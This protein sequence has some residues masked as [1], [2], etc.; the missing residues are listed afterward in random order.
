MPQVRVATGSWTPFLIIRRMAYRLGLA[1]HSRVCLLPRK[2]PNP[3]LDQIEQAYIRPQVMAYYVIILGVDG[4]HDLRE[5]CGKSSTQIRESC[6]HP[7]YRGLLRYPPP[8][9]HLWAAPERL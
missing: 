2:Y 7:S 5:H 3:R 1:G 6:P 4:I 9:G 8:T